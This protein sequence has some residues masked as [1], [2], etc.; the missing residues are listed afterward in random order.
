[1]TKLKSEMKVYLAGGWFDDEQMERLEAVKKIIIDLGYG[2]FSPK[3]EALCSPDSSMDWRRQVY[4]GNI[5]AIR[6]CNFM[7]AITD[8]KD[9]G[10]IHETGIASA[11]NIPIVYF[12]ET[13][14]DN[15]FNLMLAQSGTAVAKSRDELSKIL[16][17]PNFVAS[18]FS[19]ITYK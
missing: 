11:L 18:L 19:H 9:I 17:D 12:A 5:N 6:T 16:N 13:L 1:M 10:T 2:I 3:D 8:K 7:V 15:K 4:E 14:G